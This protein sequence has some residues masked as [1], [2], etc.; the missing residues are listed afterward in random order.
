MIEKKTEQCGSLKGVNLKP[1]LLCLHVG[2]KMN[3]FYWYVVLPL[4][5]INVM[6]IAH[7]ED[8]EGK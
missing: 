8:M 4:G 5:V 2:G 6:I 1:A 3:L 7:K